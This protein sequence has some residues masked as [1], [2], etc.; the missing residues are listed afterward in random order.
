M[1]KTDNQNY[2]YY[3]TQAK[4]FKPSFQGAN[5][6]KGATARDE[7]AQFFE[8]TERYRKPENLMP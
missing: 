1:E 2:T 7:H 5:T 3:T 4:M 8:G 6:N